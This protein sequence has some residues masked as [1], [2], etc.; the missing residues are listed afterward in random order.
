[1]VTPTR[2]ITS[3]NRVVG[4]DE[5]RRNRAGAIAGRLAASQYARLVSAALLGVLAVAQALA[6]WNASPA[7]TTVVN[8]S[9]S[10]LA[11]L[12]LA[13]TCLAATLPVGWSRG[14][15]SGFAR[16]HPHG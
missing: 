7:A 13:L 14:R 5:D 11:R 6:Q 12:G 9:V 1:M 16:F 2:L 15:P 3:D 10:E 4:Q 8:G